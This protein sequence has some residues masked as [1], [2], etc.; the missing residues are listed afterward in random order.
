MRLQISFILLLITAATA[1][2][3]IWRDFAAAREGDPLPRLLV[4]ALAPVA[5][6]TIFLLGRILMKVRGARNRVRG[7]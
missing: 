1:T 4:F 7:R 6:V 2:S 5:L 3:I